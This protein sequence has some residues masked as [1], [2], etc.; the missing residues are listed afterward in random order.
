MPTWLWGVFKAAN[1]VMALATGSHPGV[2]VL[3]HVVG[4]GFG[5]GVALVMRLA[6]MDKELVAT[7]EASSSLVMSYSSDVEEAQRLLA[8]G[9]L[10]GARRH[11]EHRSLGPLRARGARVR[12]PSSPRAVNRTPP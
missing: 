6:G 4:I 11:F 2:A 10:V 3:A 7:D 5:V 8:K 12:R 9:D 1:D